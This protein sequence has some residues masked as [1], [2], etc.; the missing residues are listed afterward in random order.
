MR[1]EVE[2]FVEILDES[3]ELPTYKHEDDSG[4][5]VRATKDV[6]I[7]PNETVV[8]PT[9]LKVAIP[10]GY[11]IQVRPRSGVSLKTPLRI[12]NSIG[13]VD[14]GY[15]DEIGVIITNT[16]DIDLST[17]SKTGYYFARNIEDKGN[18]QGAY[19][20]HKGDRIAQFVL[21][22]VPQIKWNKVKS[23]KDIGT[24]RQGGFGS[25]GTRS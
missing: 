23:V 25:T 14:A 6:I 21:Q 18:K 19:V 22:E 12:S 5:D 4:M 8:I 11:E 13:T 20:I 7:N 3:V 1:K 2:V 9:G 10:D 17:D 16:S 15:R 24:D